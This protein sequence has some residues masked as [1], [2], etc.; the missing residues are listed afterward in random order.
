MWANLVESLSDAVSSTRGLP[1]PSLYILAV[2]FV[3]A[4]LSRSLAAMAIAAML[5]S[6][7]ASILAHPGDQRGWTIFWIV[8]IANLL[9]S[10]LAYH[11]D[12]LSRRLSILRDNVEEL[13]NELADLRPKYEREVMWRK[14]GQSD[15]PQECE[16]LPREPARRFASSEAST[17][18]SKFNSQSQL[19]ARFAPVWPSMVIPPRSHRS[20]AP[21]RSER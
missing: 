19:R 3:A 4:L 7:A 17:G 12:R 11:R 14:A 9:A 6:I 18:A 15:P 10:A 16:E 8:N 2:A 13:R 21:P 1:F 20:A 5:V